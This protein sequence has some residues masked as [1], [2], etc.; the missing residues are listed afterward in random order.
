MTWRHHVTLAFLVG[1]AGVGCYKPDITDGG[2]RCA[3]GVDGGVCPEGFHCAPNGTCRAGPKMVC[4]TASPAI[5]PLCTAA[6]GAECDPICQNGCECGRCNLVGASLMCVPPGNKQ[7]GDLCNAANDDCAPGN[8]CIAYC[9]PSKPAR[10]YRFCSKGETTDH[11]KCEGNKCDIPV[12]PGVPPDWIVCEP[13]LEKC[14]PVGDN[15]DCKEP[16]TYGCYV[17]PTG[18]PVCDCRGTFVEDGVCGPYNSCLPGLSC[19]QLRAGEPAL[20]LKTCRLTGNDCPGGAPCSP[21]GYD[22]YGFCRS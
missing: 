5:Q 4:T 3:T 2:L 15:S 21:A 6:I 19:V 18:S 17:G 14:N 16:S 10:C 20:C 11:S 1:C 8:V 12:N 7:R 22:T 13:P 9:G